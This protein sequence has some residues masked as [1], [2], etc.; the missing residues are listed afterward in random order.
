MMLDVGFRSVCPIQPHCL[1][2]SI[3]MG[4]WF[5][6]SVLEY[7]SVAVVYEGFDLSCGFLSCP[8]CF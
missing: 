1:F 5:L 2:I 3:S 8:P 6:A 7:A 4:Q